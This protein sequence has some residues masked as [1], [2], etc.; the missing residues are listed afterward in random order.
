MPKI[1]ERHG[2]LEERYEIVLKAK[3]LLDFRFL[4][5]RIIEDQ[6]SVILCNQ[7]CGM[8]LE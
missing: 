5:F 3:G 4:V 7:F 1:T 6:I 2:K 8:F